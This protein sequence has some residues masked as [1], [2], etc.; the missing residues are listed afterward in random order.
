MSIHTLKAGL[1]LFLGLL[2]GCSSDGSGNTSAD[3]LEI[4][5]LGTSDCA[6][7]RCGEYP[8]DDCSDWDMSDGHS[9]DCMLD[10]PR[11]GPT[12]PIA[13][14]FECYE[15]HIVSCKE[16]SNVVVEFKGGERYKYDGL[17]G[18][19]G[20]FGAGDKEIVGVW[21][22]AG[23]NASGDGPGYGMRFDS[24]ADCGDDGTG[25]TG[26]DDG[27]GGT[28]GAGGTGASAGAGGMG[29]TGGDD[30]YCS[31]D[32]GDSDSDSDSDGY[33]D[34]G[35]SGSD[36]DCDCDYGRDCKADLECPHGGKYGNIEVE[37]ECHEVHIASCKELSNVVIEFEDGEHRK[38][39]DLDGH[40]AT[41]GVGER[42]IAGVWVKAGNNKSGDGP[43][44]G[45]RFDSDA[46]CDGTGGTGGA[47]GEGGMAGSG[48][49]GGTGG[50]PGCTVNADCDTGEICNDNVCVSD[51]NL[52]CNTGAC[53]DDPGL[54]GQCVDA[55]LI[56]LADNI[57]EEECVLASLLICRECTTNEGCS[58]GE[59]CVDNICVVSVSFA[60][61]IQPYFEPGLAN[62]VQ[63]HSE[64]FAQKG[65]KL[66][67]Y[68][69]ILAGSVDASGPLVVAG[70]SSMGIL[71][72]KLDSNHNNGP[73]DAAF[74]PILAQWIDEGAMDN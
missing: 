68:A 26:G 23:N 64:A 20:T 33:C 65:V 41:L 35:G 11:G 48:G 71:I 55:F 72:P 52:F 61:Q 50:A 6:T 36:R 9:D 34:D 1:F 27:M 15:V 59:T 30:C 47:G 13:A 14:R 38:Y 73:D 25:G 40:C 18:H 17:E 58:A 74:V 10:C 32:G 31:C 28:G 19:Y 62:C 42:Q 69:N 39:D 70:D 43:G 29:G 12:G 16:L 66:D 49:M 4:V 54:R 3:A 44:Y 2:V 8:D 46:D 53:D 5:P 7:D 21:V 37:F 45:E 24:D 57:D 63:C 67:S 51:P 56:C 22:K 60:A